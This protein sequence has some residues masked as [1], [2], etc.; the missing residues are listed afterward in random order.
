MH[1]YNLM[2]T[3]ALHH[4]SLVVWLHLSDRVMVMVISKS[5]RERVMHAC[6]HSKRIIHGK[7]IIRAWQEHVTSSH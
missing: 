7:R 4:L 1:A 3:G 2:I 5:M 6:M